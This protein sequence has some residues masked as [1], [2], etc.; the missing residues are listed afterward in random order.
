MAPCFNL[1]FLNIREVKHFSYFS[2]YFYFFFGKSPHILGPIIRW[3][4]CSNLYLFLL[5]LS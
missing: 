2:T 5:F 1:Y 3:D 4:M